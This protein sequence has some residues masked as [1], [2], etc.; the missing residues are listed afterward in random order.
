MR[1]GTR[2][3]HKGSSKIY[4]SGHT[5]VEELLYACS[6][7][8]PKN[9][10]PVHGE[11]RH[12]VVNGGSAARTGVKSRNAMLVEDGMCVEV[13]KGRVEVV[14]QVSCGYVYVGGTSVEELGEQ[15]LCNHRVLTEEGFVA[16]YVVMELTTGI[17]LTGPAVITRGVAEDAT[18]FRDIEPRVADVL[19]E[20]ASGDKSTVY[21]IERVVRRTLGCWVSKRSHRA[22]M[23][24]SSV[25]GAE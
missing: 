21:D 18:M 6:T 14:D 4:A 19:A 25:V 22:S 3:I 7:V 12:L 10:M 5:T 15:G 16:V 9:M 11:I 13:K 17:I 8:K 23:I 24:V 2:A 1:L 20:A